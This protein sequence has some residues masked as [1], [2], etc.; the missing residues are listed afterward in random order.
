MSSNDFIPYL[1]CHFPLVVRYWNKSGFCTDSVPSIWFK[2]SRRG[3]RLMTM[4]QTITNFPTFLETIL[5][6]LTS[7]RQAGVIQDRV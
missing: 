7:L 4:D 5:I 6:G 1:C 2:V 3:R